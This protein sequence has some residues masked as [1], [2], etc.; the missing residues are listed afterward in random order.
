MQLKI[1]SF[2]H[3]DRREKHKR[4]AFLATQEHQNLPGLPQNEKAYWFKHKGNTPCA[5]PSGAEP[6]DTERSIHEK[7]HKRDAFSDYSE[8]P[9]CP[10]EQIKIHM[11][12]TTLKRPL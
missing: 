5:G 11:S 10:T 4:N 6:Q 7:K 3:Q 2:K 1:Y 9:S 8:P 12:K